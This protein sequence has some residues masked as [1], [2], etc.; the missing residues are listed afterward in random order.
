MGKDTEIGF[1]TK[2]ECEY[3]GTALGDTM[4]RLSHLLTLDLSYIAKVEAQKALRSLNPV[5]AKFVKF[6]KNKE[7]K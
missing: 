7:D 6:D 3:I 4:A 1:I 5:Y 2:K